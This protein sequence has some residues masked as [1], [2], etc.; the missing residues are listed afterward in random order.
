MYLD[1]EALYLSKKN[2]VLMTT[3]RNNTEAKILKTLQDYL[4]QRKIYF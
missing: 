2:G 4:C 1:E 3:R